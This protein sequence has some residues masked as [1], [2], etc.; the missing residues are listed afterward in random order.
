MIAPVK[1]PTL[2]GRFNEPLPKALVLFVATPLLLCCGVGT[3]AAALGGDSGEPEAP[4]TPSVT[5]P[6]EA[7]PSAVT[8]TE[9]VQAATTSAPTTAPAPPT[10]TAAYVYY[11]NC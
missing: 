2:P 11:A 1:L 8:T 7:A 9:P 10:T 5:A 3:L 6:A 4:T